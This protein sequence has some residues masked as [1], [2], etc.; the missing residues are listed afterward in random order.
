MGRPRKNDYVDNDELKEL[1]TKYIVSNPGDTGQWIDKYEKTMETRCLGKPA[2]WAEVQDF[3]AFRRSL[4]ASERPLNEFQA[5][6]DKLI[7]IFYKIITG[8]MAS[9]KI[10]DDDDMKQDCMVA[11]LKYV[12]RY[13]YRKDTSAFAYVSEIV[14][15][16]INLHLSRE[17]D[18]RLDGNLVYEHELF[19]T[20]GVD[21]M[22][23]E[24]PE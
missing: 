3:I 24:Y 11:L 6:A 22:D 8:R 18:A 14:T 19:D 13:D 4:Y 2:K 20:R 1:I 5:V 7:P 17:K 16:A 21:E 10:F 15:Q 12:N 9:Y 23:G